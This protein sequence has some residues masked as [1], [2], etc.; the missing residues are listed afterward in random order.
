MKRRSGV[1]V[2]R[3]A[4]VPWPQQWAVLPRGRFLAGVALLVVLSAASGAV[5]MRH[6]LDGWFSGF[7]YVILFSLL[8]AELA[9]LL[10]HARLR[11]RRGG[12]AP[13]RLKAGRD[14]STSLEMPY[15]RVQYAGFVLL[16]LTAASPFVLGVIGAIDIANPQLGRVVLNACAALVLLSLPALMLR[17]TFA[18]GRVQLSTGGIHHRGWTHAS[19]LP[20]QSVI[21]VRAVPGDGP[22]IWVVAVEGAHW[23]RRQLARVWKEDRLPDAPILRI[24]G[25]DLAGDPALLHAL[26]RHYHEH[27]EERAE[28]G[29]RSGVKRA[30]AGEFLGHAPSA[31]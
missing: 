29:T 28:L 10:A 11:P 9:V 23:Q 13:L 19:Y 27:P 26:L 6:Y 8:F 15:S 3:S 5:A 21:D 20:W 16:A 22:E 12:A 4:R 1:A 18:V 24:F 30:K 25:R 14:A 7:K 31:A 2:A 17:G